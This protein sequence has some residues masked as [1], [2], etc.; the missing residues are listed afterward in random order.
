MKA[1]WLKHLAFVLLIILLVPLAMP[2]FVISP[3]YGYVSTFNSPE[4]TAVASAIPGNLVPLRRAAFV[5]RDTNSYIDEFAYMAAVPSSVF[6]HSDTQYVSP[7][8]LTSGSDS[9][10]WFIDDWTEYVESDG[11]PT[12]IIGI[13]DL[14]LDTVDEIQQKS[15]IP[16][17]PRIT[18]SNST[19]IAAQIASM[20]WD[21]SDIAVFALADDRF[22]APTVST[23][24]AS[25]RFLD[26][27]IPS[28]TSTE[29]VTFG[30]TSN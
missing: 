13:G 22:P 23:G 2:L 27:V 29:S 11:G 5:A 25:F 24:E 8:I 20:D 19:E 21:S 30:T 3:N 28:Y 17:F 16:M 4:K 7:L 18:G 12:Q 15:G 1:D 10:S 9:E 26:S 6:L 14:P